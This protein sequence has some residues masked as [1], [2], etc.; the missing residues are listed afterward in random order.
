VE[1][2]SLGGENQRR[3]SLPIVDVHDFDVRNHAANRERQLVSVTNWRNRPV[4][5]LR[6]P[7]FKAAKLPVT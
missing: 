4:A 7:R 2:T 6:Q 3:L 5:D 1:P